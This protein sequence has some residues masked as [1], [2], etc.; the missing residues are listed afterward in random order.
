MKYRIIGIE[1]HQIVLEFRKN[2]KEITFDTYEEAEKYLNKIIQ[3]AIIPSKYTLKITEV[4]K[5]S[6][7]Q[8]SPDLEQMS[9]S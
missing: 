4:N 9:H 7:S 3:E 5:E 6:A 2:N 1:T 8:D